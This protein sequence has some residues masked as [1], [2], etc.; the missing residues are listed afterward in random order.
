MVTHEPIE[1]DSGQRY[2]SNNVMDSESKRCLQEHSQ[3]TGTISMDRDEVINSA[4]SE[5]VQPSGSSHNVHTAAAA[6]TA[7]CGSS[8]STSPSSVDILNTILTDVE[9][10]EL[11]ACAL[12]IPWRVMYAEHKVHSTSSAA[13]AL[14]AHAAAVESFTAGPN[15]SNR[16]LATRYARSISSSTSSQ[17]TRYS[18]SNNLLMS[19]PDLSLLLEAFPCICFSHNPIQYSN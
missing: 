14:I 9:T 1:Q 5:N 10:S 6:S 17:L 19:H 4:S 11:R 2:L 7:S 18:S 13:T 15:S 12:V 8:N 16:Y 3:L